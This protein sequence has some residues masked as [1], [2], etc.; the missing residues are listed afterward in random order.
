M[1]GRV[2]GKLREIKTEREAKKK[3]RNWEKARTLEEEIEKVRKKYPNLTREE[4]VV[5][6]RKNLKKRRRAKVVRGAA[7]AGKIL[8]RGAKTGLR[9]ARRSYRYSRRRRRFR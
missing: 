5:I 4:A 8:F 9:Y 2:K 6:A 1:L 7:K 3:I